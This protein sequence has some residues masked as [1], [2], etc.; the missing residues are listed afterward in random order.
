MVKIV[1]TKK[2]SFL[3][4]CPIYWRSYVGVKLNSNLM[5]EQPKGPTTPTFI[6]AKA[7]VVEFQFVFLTKQFGFALLQKHR[8]IYTIIRKY[9]R[10]I[11]GQL[12]S[13]WQL[14]WS[15]ICPKRFKRQTFSPLCRLKQTAQNSSQLLFLSGSDQTLVSEHLQ[16]PNPR[17]CPPVWDTMIQLYDL[18]CC[19]HDKLYVNAYLSCETVW[20]VTDTFLHDSLSV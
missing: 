15:S 13:N 11:S 3:W 20:P 19:R 12:C 14:Y 16:G 10:V 8:N 7:T 6:T 18:L 1:I 9:L 4:Q 17:R 2:K 5:G